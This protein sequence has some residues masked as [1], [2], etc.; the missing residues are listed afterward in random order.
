MTLE[1]DIQAFLAEPESATSAAADARATALDL[2]LPEAC[3]AGVIDNLDLL[4]RQAGL[5]V[6]V[7][8]DGPVEAFQP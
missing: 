8:P 2:V 5:F 3:R 1:T 4:R 6:A 7:A